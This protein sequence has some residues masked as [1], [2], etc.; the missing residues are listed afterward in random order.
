MMTRKIPIS[1]YIDIPDFE[2][3]ETISRDK[4]KSVSQLVRES[5][6]KFLKSEKV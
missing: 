4:D 5:V 3:L 2:K 1:V 6:Q